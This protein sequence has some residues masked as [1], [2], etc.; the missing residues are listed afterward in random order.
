MRKVGINMDNNYLYDLLKYSLKRWENEE[1][2]AAALTELDKEMS[3]LAPE[4]WN[5]LL[6]LAKNHSV[7]SLVCETIENLKS[8]SDILVKRTQEHTRSV[9]Q[10]SYRIFITTRMILNI[11]EREGIKACA[12]KGIAT[13]A[14]YDVPEL[15]KSG[16]VDIL[17]SDPSKTDR[18]VEILERVGF[19]KDEKQWTLHHVAMTRGNV[20]LEL[21]TMLAEPFDNKEINTFMDKQMQGIETHF[22]KDEVF[23]I[24]FTKLDDG[25]H[26]YELLLHM[27]QHFLNSGFGIKLLCDWVRFWSREH[28]EAARKT[29]LSLVKDSGI[30]TFSDMVT[31]VCVKYLGLERECVSWMNIYEDKLSRAIEEED[32]KTFMVEI[33]FTEEFGRQNGERVVAVRGTGVGAYFK[34]FHHQMRNSFPGAS[35]CFLLWPVLWII[36][37]IRFVHNNKKVRGVSTIKVLKSAG[38]RGSLVEKMKLFEKRD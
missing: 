24:G 1:S 4:E 16:D 38:G 19:I 25:Y 34:E 33:V 14:E 8:T 20:V 22:V 27:I 36:T 35:K 37:F 5:R 6:E 17:I 15:R 10:I 11:L 21:H 31:R 18:A 32:T 26:G 9:C 3:G 12:L 7:L 29:Y 23:G 13:A 30:K 28:D 2:K